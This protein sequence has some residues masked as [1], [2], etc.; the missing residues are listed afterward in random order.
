M[1]P[2]VGIRTYIILM[3]QVPLTLIWAFVLIDVMRQPQMRTRRKV[4][5]A[6]ACSVIWPM[7][8]VYL[9]VRPQRGR[10]ERAVDRDDPQARLVDAVLDR[11]AGRLDVASF[12][13]VVAELRAGRSA[14]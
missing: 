10:A 6:I 13:Q 14:S 12:E 7:Q 11:E 9:L 8:L 5:W 3:V 4:A 1:N 2:D